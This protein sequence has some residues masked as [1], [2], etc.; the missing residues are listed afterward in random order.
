LE[1]EAL[2]VQELDDCRQ[3]KEIPRGSHRIRY[4]DI[5]IGVSDAAKSQPGVEEVKSED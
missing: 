5:T 2:A 3:E 4:R 1:N